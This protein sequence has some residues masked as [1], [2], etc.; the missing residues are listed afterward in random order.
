M[1]GCVKLRDDDE[2]GEAMARASLRPW[3]ECLVEAHHQA[4]LVQENDGSERTGF[5]ER[6]SAGRVDALSWLSENQLADLKSY[7]RATLCKV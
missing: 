1:L 2:S 6:E 5:V 7:D 4:V 3:L